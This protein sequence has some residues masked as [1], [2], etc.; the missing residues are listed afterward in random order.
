MT[1]ARTV[2]GSVHRGSRI[3][4]Q[5]DSLPRARLGYEAPGLG[6]SVFEK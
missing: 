4:P 2:A 3:Q 1:V 6:T 5:V